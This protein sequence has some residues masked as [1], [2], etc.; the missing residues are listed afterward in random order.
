MSEHTDN[1]ANRRHELLFKQ[2]MNE[3]VV[4]HPKLL[5]DAVTITIISR[6]TGKVLVLESPSRHVKDVEKHLRSWDFGYTM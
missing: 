1:P 2:I 3:V 6:C 5:T 4:G